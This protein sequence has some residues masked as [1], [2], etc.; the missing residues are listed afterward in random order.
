MR[1]SASFDAPSG[2]ACASKRQLSASRERSAS[3]AFR[4]SARLALRIS[5]AADNVTCAAIV[6]ARSVIAS[7]SVAEPGRGPAD[8]IPESRGIEE[9][10]KA[11][12]MPLHQL[13]TRHGASRNLMQVWQTRM[14]L[15]LCD[16][17]VIREV[18]GA[19]EFLRAYRGYLRCDPTELA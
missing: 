4:N 7:V 11:R 1:E 19:A 16:K 12:P 3:G 15:V 8:V 18:G 5:A 10:N 14:V 9:G 6:T 17:I 2:N 13:E